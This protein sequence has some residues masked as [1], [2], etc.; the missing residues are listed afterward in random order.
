VDRHTVDEAGVTFDIEEPI[1]VVE[2]VGRFAV[3]PRVG[4]H[5]G[6]P[7]V[8]FG[9][10]ARLNAFAREMDFVSANE[11]LGVV[12]VGANV[13]VGFKDGAVSLFGGLWRMVTSPIQTAKALGTGGKGLVEY[14]ALVARGQRNPKEDVMNLTKAFYIDQL[15]QTAAQAGFSYPEAVTQDSRDCVSHVTW[16]RDG[17]RAL[18]EAAAILLPAAA[19][20]WVAEGAETA[21]VAEA[22]ELASAASSAEATGE[23]SDIGDGYQELLKQGAMF[24]EAADVA[25]SARRLRK[26]EDVARKV[27]VF[28]SEAA[29]AAEAAKIAEVSRLT[30]SEQANLASLAGLKAG[31]RMANP[32]FNRI[33]GAMAQLDRA[34]FEVPAV[35][36]EELPQGVQTEFYYS[37]AV[38]ERHLIEQYRQLKEWCAL[39]DSDIALLKRGKSIPI[40]WGPYAGDVTSVDH[41]IPVTYA[42]ELENNLLNLRVY[43]LKANKLIRGA[44]IDEETLDASRQFETLGWKPDDDLDRLLSNVPVSAMVN[45]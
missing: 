33:L 18:E 22:A 40:R 10:A 12:G 38:L 5:A 31:L 45:Q 32:R 29:K 44:A 4:A 1:P 24:D 37:K 34:G 36:D 23:A 25:N 28:D 19:V 41:R 13:G 6:Q 7:I 21:K 14:L 27:E 42:G 15:C 9:D 35:L 8:F 11:I 3:F 2:E 20:K 30:I 17:G 43:P 26:F 39:D 16:S